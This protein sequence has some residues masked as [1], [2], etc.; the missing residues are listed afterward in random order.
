MIDLTALRM[1]L[2]LIEADAGSFDRLR[3]RAIEIAALLEE[4]T[5][6]PMVKEQ[7]GY[8]QALQEQEFWEGINVPM[9]EEMRLRLR[10]LVP[11]IDKKSRE[12][13]YTNFKDEVLGVRKEAVF[14]M[15]KM[16]GVQYAKKIEAYLNAHLNNIVIHRLRTNQPLT[17][18]DLESLEA[19]LKQI[20]EEDGETLLANL[21]EQRQAPSLAHFIRG[22][23]GMDREAAQAAFSEFLSD[24]TLTSSQ[25]RF[26][27]TIID[28]LT[29]RGVMDAKA[30]YEPPFSHLHAGGP[31]GLFAGKENVIDGIFGALEATK[32]KIITQTG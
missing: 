7:L 8:L 16:T 31:D 1:Q 22:L 6:I 13:V 17:A 32:P 19:T 26:I 14:E 27:E 4:K 23:V 20:G 11:F 15:P 3:R 21:L 30:L 24:R 5:S 10:Q 9:L 28:Q 29:S 2:A 25:V 12:I 18:T